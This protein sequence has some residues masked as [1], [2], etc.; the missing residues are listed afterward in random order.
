M[1]S[2]IYMESKKIKQTSEYNK[3]ERDSHREQASGYQQRGKE[4][5]QD[6]PRGL[7]GTNYCKSPCYIP[8]T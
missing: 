6:R 2:L 3:K 4:R 8:V 7:R 5:R 1:T